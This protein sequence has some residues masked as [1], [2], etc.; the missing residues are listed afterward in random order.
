MGINGRSH[1]MDAGDAVVS[2]DVETVWICIK[3]YN[4]LT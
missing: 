3:R 2:K 1:R 4:K